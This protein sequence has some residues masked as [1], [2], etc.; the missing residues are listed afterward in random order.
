METILIFGGTGCLGRHLIQRYI[1]KYNIVN[2]SRDEHKHWA[3]DQEFGAGKIKH[4]IGDAIDP[5]LVQQ[6]LIQYNPEHI[7]ILHALKHVDRCQENL[8]A[9]IT[10]N[11]LSIKNI[12]DVIH[13]NSKQLQNLKRVLF[14]STDKAPSPISAYGMCKGLCE[15]LIVEKAR[16][17]SNVRFLI[18]RYGNVLNSTSSLLPALLK[19]KS[20]VY[21]LTD[22]R[23]TRFWMT[24]EQACDTIQ[25]ALDHG[26][27]GEVIIP[28]LRAF[29]IKDM[30]NYIAKLKGKRVELM[31]LRPAER[32]YEV[33]IS[34]TESMRTFEKES[35]YYHI[36]PEFMKPPLIEP[37]T[38]DSTMNIIETHDELIEMFQQM[39]LIGA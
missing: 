29:Y 32:L 36:V 11:L 17:I 37:F 1:G 10:T 15:A 35:G 22:E 25:Y 9:C 5:I 13:S 2:F 20:D 31:G 4:I 28:K 21:Y 3:I 38:Y 12:L 14:T 18:V 39:N 6:A 26:K 7:F 16:C 19:N 23:M 30:I 24:I 27:T 33:L 8:H 34:T